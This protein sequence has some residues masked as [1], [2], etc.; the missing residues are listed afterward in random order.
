MWQGYQ[1]RNIAS[2]SNQQADKLA[3][4][5]D[6]GR[7]RI[8]RLKPIPSLPRDCPTGG[9]NLVWTAIRDHHPV[10]LALKG[11]PY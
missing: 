4:G 1:Y 9:N 3:I 8:T 7:P 5:I 6:Y 10:E 11:P 2:A